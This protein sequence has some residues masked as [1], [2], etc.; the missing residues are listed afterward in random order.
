MFQDDKRLSPDQTAGIVPHF[1][2]C[3][4]WRPFRSPTRPY[5]ELRMQ[6]CQFEADLTYPLKV[7]GWLPC[8]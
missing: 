1:V 4:S 8:I 2:P 5:F 7:P 6:G 3:V